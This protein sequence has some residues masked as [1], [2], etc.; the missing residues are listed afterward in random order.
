MW[1][2]RGLVK[3]R[4]LLMWFAHELVEKVMGSLVPARPAA[5]LECS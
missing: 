1:S 4:S 3:R 2:I 5:K